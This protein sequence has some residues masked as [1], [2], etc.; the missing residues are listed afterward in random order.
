[1]TYLE[2]APIKD[3]ENPLESMMSRFDAAVK[4]LGISDEMYNILKIPARQV[5]VGLPITMDNGKIEVFEGYRV[6]HSTILG[7]GK[8]G[9]RLDPDVTLDEVRALAAWMTWKCAVVDIPYGGAKG[10]IACDPRKMSAGEIERLIRAYTLAL[11]DIFGPDKDIPAPDMG[12]GPREMAWLMDE[13]SKAK[14]MTTHAVVTGKPLVLGGSLGRTEATGRGVTITAMVALEKLGIKPENCTAAVQGFGNVGSHA[15]LLLHERGVKVLAISDI[16]GAYYNAMGIDLKD[17]V[18]YRDENNGTLEGYKNAEKIDPEELLFL[19]VDLLVPAAKEDVITFANASKI[20]AKL[21]VEG[22]NG[23]T[24][25]RA[26]DIINSKG[27]MVVPDILANAGGV[28]VS[29]FE[30]VQNRIGYKWELERINRRC[31][32]ALKDAFNVVFKVSQQHNVSLRLAA[33]IVAI[34]KV[35]STYKYR[36]GFG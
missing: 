7:P 25:A 27:I 8:G 36:G 11:Q 33:Y 1:M 3:K 6:I 4:I 2:P 16:S 12:T 18:K 28:T 32:R 21:I 30:W 22:A 24:S 29:Y 26:D 10:G 34:D 19:P 35:A 31:E 14:G 20:Q 15:A 9:V 13:Y 5:I 17:A 23:P